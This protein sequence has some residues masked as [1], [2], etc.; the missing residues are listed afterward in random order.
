[1]NTFTRF[2]LLFSLSFPVYSAPLIHCEP[3]SFLD[4]LKP[5]WLFTE[6][7]WPLTAAAVGFLLLALWAM[8]TARKS[9]CIARE[10]KIW[11][12]CV[13]ISCISGGALFFTVPKYLPVVDEEVIMS[14]DDVAKG[15]HYRNDCFL[16]DQTKSTVTLSCKPD[17]RSITV[18]MTDYGSA[19]KAFTKAKNQLS[20]LYWNLPYNNICSAE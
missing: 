10:R 6:P 4:V 7:R 12:L 5:N 19:V 8:F 20:M 15:R 2:S 17:G 1:M 9:L 18:P 11:I 3:G 16:V 14:R 13:V